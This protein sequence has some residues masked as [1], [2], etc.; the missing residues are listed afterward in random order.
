MREMIGFTQAKLAR[1]IDV[2]IRSL[3]R[4]ETN[5]TAIPK[6]AE[7]ALKYIAEKVRRQKAR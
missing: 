5:Q 7:L 6:M 2:T 1:E 3:T 4:W